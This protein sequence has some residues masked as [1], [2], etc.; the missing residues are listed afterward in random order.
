MY[1]RRV[2]VA[3]GLGR[4]EIILNKWQSPIRTACLSDGAG[5]FK[6][7]IPLLYICFPDQDGVSC[8]LFANK[9]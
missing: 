5:R 9:Y 7:K 3:Q 2:A 6:E 1:I 4:A 8:L